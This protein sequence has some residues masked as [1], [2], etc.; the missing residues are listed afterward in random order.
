MDIMQ[1]LIF[2]VIV[3]VL[4]MLVGKVAFSRNTQSIHICLFGVIDFK[5]QFYD[6]QRYDDNKSGS[7]NNH[8]CND[9]Q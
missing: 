1:L 3:V 6:V 8:L 2:I 9:N 5:A 4:I 7:Q